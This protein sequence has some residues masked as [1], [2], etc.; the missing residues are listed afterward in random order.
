MRL[1]VQMAIDDANRAGGIGGAQLELIAKDHGNDYSPD[2]PAIALRQTQEL[3]DD[4]RTIAIV[5][6]FASYV[7]RSMI[8]ASNAAGLLI[9]S[10]AVT[11]PNLTKPSLGAAE[12]RSAHPDRS[13]F[14]RIAPSDDI[15]SRALARYAIRDL[16]AKTALVIDDADAGITVVADDF[17]REFTRLG[18]QVERRTLAFDAG[19]VPQDSLTPWSVRGSPPGVV[20]WVGYTRSGGAPLRVAMM[21]LGHKETPLISW[22]GLWDG[23]GS[24]PDSF[25]GASGTAAIGTIVT[26]ASLPLPKADFVERYRQAFGQEPHEYAGASYACTETVLQALRAIASTGTSADQLREA[27]R[28]YVTDTQHHFDTVLGSVAF[29]KNGDA[30]QQFVTFYRVEVSAAGGKGDWVIFKQQ[31]FGPAG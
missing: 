15:Q 7:A 20:F 13:A 23:D 19:A 3:V 28:A 11:Q 25:I 6:P 1:A 26:H 27:V 24:D 8:P 10:P 18:G 5:G 17:E 21:Q 9:C 29:D 12:L 16:A 30:V 22:D 14:V 2:E 31:D 4:P